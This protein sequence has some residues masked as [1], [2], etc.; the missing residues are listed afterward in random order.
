MTSV[1]E[2]KT[3]CLLHGPCHNLLLFVMTR[4]FDPYAL[5]IGAGLE[6]MTINPMAWDGD[7]NPKVCLSLSFLLF[8]EGFSV[9]SFVPKI[10]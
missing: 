3:L 2:Y 5:G 6:S 7:V 4:L 8:H 10:C 9:N 1:K